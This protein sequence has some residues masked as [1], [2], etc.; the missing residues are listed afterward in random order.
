M[1][2]L[3]EKLTGLVSLVKLQNV[4]VLLLAQLL[5]ARFVFAPG[6]S[7][8]T[9]LFGRRFVFMLLATGSA[10]A[11][12]YII[13]HFYN[14]K[15]DWINRPRQSMMERQLSMSKK[16]YLYF[17]LNALTL[18][19]AAFIS[20][21]A[22]LFFAVYE[23]LIW[24]YFHKIQPLPFWHELTL[25]FLTVYPFFGVM[26]FFKSFNR[27]VLWAG[28]LFVLL[29]LLK[30]IIKNHLTLRGDVAQNIHTVLVAKGEKFQQ[31]M[32]YF[33]VFFIF[34]MLIGAFRMK[35]SPE[36]TYFIYAVFVML[37]AEIVL[38]MK[39][40]YAAAYAVVKMIIISGVFALFLL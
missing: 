16:L 18:V 12:G 10:I 4:A 31:R 34:L 37:T 36:F 23:F 24:L 30:E 33:L 11:A 14:L 20:W 9:L 19:F 6:V 39:K 15:R 29:I 21:R 1:T 26:L 28:I 25:A 40:K 8:K 38:Y 2:E 3:N 27:F 7:F 22:V 32:F 5:T 35:F 13:N 17:A